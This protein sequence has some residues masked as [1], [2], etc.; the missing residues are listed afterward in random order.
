MPGGQT[1]ERRTWEDGTC[2]SVGPSRDDTI[3]PGPPGP[4][5]G[6]GGVPQSPDVFFTHVSGRAT[7]ADTRVDALVL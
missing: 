2:H 7:E 4:V 6:T 3:G 1:A 5:G